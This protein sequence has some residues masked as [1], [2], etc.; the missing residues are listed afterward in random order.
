MR[1]GRI[2]LASLTAL[3]ACS[4]AQGAPSSAGAVTRTDSLRLLHTVVPLFV[5]AVESAS[6][7]PIVKSAAHAVLTLGALAETPLSGALYLV[8]SLFAVN[9]LAR[10][11][12]RALLRC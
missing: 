2:I 5:C 1:F 8:A 7:A 3:V 10:R 12:Q 11:H 6:P 4:Y 9:V